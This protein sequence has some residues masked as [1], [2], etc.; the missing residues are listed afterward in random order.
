MDS[1]DDHLTNQEKK[2]KKEDSEKMTNIKG[3]QI[4]S[5][6]QINRCNPFFFFIGPTKVILSQIS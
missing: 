6:N 1:P 2:K 5:A 4:R 3:G